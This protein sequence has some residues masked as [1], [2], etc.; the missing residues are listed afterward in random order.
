EAVRVPA[1]VPALV[2]GAHDGPH[3]AEQAAHL[4]EHALALD[5][6]R[7]DDRPL[8]DRQLAGLV[9][10][11]LGDPDLADVVEERDELD[12][13]ALPRLEPELV[14]DGDCQL[15]DLTAVAAG[16]GVVG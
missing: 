5:R 16:V 11:L 7:V 15:D 2:A 6:V 13:S 12:V 14:R 8:L 3:P 1:S 10:D 9:D 4:L